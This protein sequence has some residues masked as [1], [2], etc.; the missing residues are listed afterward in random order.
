MEEIKKLVINY[1]KTHNFVK[2]DGGK[3]KFQALHHKSF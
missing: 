1:F 2:Y 3:K